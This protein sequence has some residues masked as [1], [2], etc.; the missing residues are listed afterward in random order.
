MREKITILGCGI[1]WQ[2]KNEQTGVIEREGCTIH[3]IMNSDLKPAE[4]EEG[5]LGYVPVKESVGKD[6]YEVFKQYKLPLVI[7]AEFGMKTKQGGTVLY[8]KG[9]DFQSVKVK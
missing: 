4:S 2:L 8:I 7:E 5:V 3:Y 6:M 1:P 9:L